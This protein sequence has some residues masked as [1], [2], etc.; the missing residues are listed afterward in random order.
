MIEADIAAG[1]A[2]ESDRY[3]LFEDNLDSQCQPDYTKP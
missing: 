3:L 1:V 2:D